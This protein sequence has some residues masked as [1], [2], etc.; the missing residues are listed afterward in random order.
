MTPRNEPTVILTTVE[1]LRD[2]VAQAVA[3]ALDGIQPAQSPEVLTRKE[4]AELLRTSLATL[5][6]LCREGLPFHLL[7]DSRRFV[8]AELLQ[9]L[10]TDQARQVPA[11]PT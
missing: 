11:Q 4:A 6:R 7:G 2:T 8:R 5:D 10:T 9:W 1:A 3:L